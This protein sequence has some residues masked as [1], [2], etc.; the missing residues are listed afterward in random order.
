MEMWELYA[1]KNFTRLTDLILLILP[2]TY[3][4]EMERKACSSYF[5]EQRLIN[6]QIVRIDDQHHDVLRNSGRKINCLFDLG[7]R[8]SM[9][10][11]YS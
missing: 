5:F 3:V 4:K 10:T 7:K 11:A 1:Y 6:K 2:P 9:R 8:Y